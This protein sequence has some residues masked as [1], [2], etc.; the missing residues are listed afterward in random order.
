LNFL[1]TGLIVEARKH[2]VSL[3]L[4]LELEVECSGEVQT[5]VPAGKLGG[6]RGP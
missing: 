5:K 6:V 1:Y 3:Q 4:E 2:V